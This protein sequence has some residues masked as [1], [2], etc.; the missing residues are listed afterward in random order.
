MSFRLPFTGIYIYN[1]YFNL[2]PNSEFKLHN[3]SK[4]INII[5]KIHACQL[6]TSN[7]AH[8]HKYKNSSFK[9]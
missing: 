6:K 9:I 3:L 4:Y 1:N 8:S 5:W 2:Q 7:P